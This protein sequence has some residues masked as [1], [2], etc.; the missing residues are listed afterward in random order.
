MITY[1]AYGEIV[2]DSEELSEADRSEDAFAYEIHPWVEGEMNR[3]LYELDKK[4]L[5]GLR[6]GQ[7]PNPHMERKLMRHKPM[8][9]DAEE[10]KRDVKRQYADW[11][12][13][14]RKLLKQAK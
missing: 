1:R 2:E 9:Q 12:T 5:A 13:K 7:W 11:S 6:K 14:I 8:S 4:V 10:F 3:F